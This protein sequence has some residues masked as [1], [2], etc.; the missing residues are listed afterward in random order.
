[1]LFKSLTFGHLY[2][3]VIH[4]CLVTQQFLTLNENSAPTFRGTGLSQCSMTNIAKK[5]LDCYFKLI[6]LS[7]I[8]PM[9]KEELYYLLV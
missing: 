7:T 5:A 8:C 2:V 3:T 4:H 6:I 9:V 1:M